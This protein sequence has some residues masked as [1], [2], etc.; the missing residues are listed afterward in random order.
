MLRSLRTAN[1]RFSRIEGIMPYNRAYSRTSF[2][3]A[4]EY[5]TGERWVIFWETRRPQSGNWSEAIEKSQA[6]AIERARHL[7]KLGFVVF[8]ITGP[9]GGIFM[10]EEEIAQRLQPS[11]TVKKP[12]APDEPPPAALP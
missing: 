6:A 11:A 12:R 4:P 2:K 5:D 3:A 9:A 10:V 1:R 8:Q 7:L